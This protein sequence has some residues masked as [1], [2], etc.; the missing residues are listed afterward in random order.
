LTPY[1]IFA[2]ITYCEKKSRKTVQNRPKLSLKALKR[3]KNSKIK[4]KEGG[5]KCRNKNR[6]KTRKRVGRLIGELLFV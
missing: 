2:I 5:K 4:K 3:A 6:I 1:Y